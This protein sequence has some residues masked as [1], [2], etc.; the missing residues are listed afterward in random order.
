MANL[1][2]IPKELQK[3]T[4]LG[5][6]EY[7]EC[8]EWRPLSFSASYDIRT[9]AQDWRDDKEVFKQFILRLARQI[10]IR[11]KAQTSE[12]MM[13]FKLLT[14]LRDELP[15]KTFNE[16]QAEIISEQLEIIWKSIVANMSFEKDK[17]NFLINIIKEFLEYRL[18]VPFPPIVLNYL[19]E[20]LPTL[21][22]EDLSNAKVSFN[23]L[24]IQFN[25]QLIVDVGSRKKSLLSD[26]AIHTLWVARTAPPI[27]SKPHLV[28]A[29]ICSL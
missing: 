25:I 26:A 24:E 15:N 17:L 4:L 7:A 18:P 19:N 2:K 6:I 16:W 28:P 27:E 3:L 21:S 12:S 1:L 20:F 9:V 14:N 23:A 29:V 22:G 11:Q 8:D 10:T 5:W 13:H